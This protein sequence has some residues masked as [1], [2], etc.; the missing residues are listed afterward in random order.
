MFEAFRIIHVSCFEMHGVYKH[1][2]SSVCQ[3]P[4]YKFTPQT[5]VAAQTS[6]TI[7]SSTSPYH[8]FGHKECSAQYNK[9]G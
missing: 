6:W 4:A 5:R 3:I 7:A 8:T 2:A 9:V 1:K